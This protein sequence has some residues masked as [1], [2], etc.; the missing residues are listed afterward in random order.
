MA[1]LNSLPLCG[2]VRVLRRNKSGPGGGRGGGESGGGGGE[3][4]GG[5]GGGGWGGSSG[6]L[7]G[8]VREGGL[9]GWARGS[10]CGYV[11]VSGVE[12][13]PLCVIIALILVGWGVERSDPIGRNGASAR[14]RERES[15]CALF[16]RPPLV[17]MR[18][19]Q[20]YPDSQGLHAVPALTGYNTATGGDTHIQYI[21]YHMHIYYIICIPYCF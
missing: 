4:G 21:Q 8:S 16:E 18:L 20:G 11:V 19:E 1:T 14:I 17:C 5:G 10:G 6:G 2:S 13:I 7:G 9:W 12:I 15:A 3:E